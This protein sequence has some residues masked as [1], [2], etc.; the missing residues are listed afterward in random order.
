M[1]KYGYTYR[2]AICKGSNP[3]SLH[4]ES[5]HAN[6]SKIRVD[7]DLWGLVDPTDSI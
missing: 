7:L 6:L 4:T 3:L 5:G 1:Q 2:E